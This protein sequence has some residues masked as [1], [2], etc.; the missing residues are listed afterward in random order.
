MQTIGEGGSNFGPAELSLAVWTVVKNGTDAGVVVV[1]AAG[2]GNQDLDS[3]TYQAYMARGNS[4]AIIVG[5]GT[6]TTAHDKL[7]FSTFGSR[8]NV[9][10]WGQSVFTAGNGSHSTIGG[11]PNQVYTATFSGTGSASP[12]IAA[13]CVALQSF[14]IDRI[15]RRLTPAELR[16]VLSTTGWPQG[17]GGNIGRF[18]NLVDAAL[19]VFQ[20]G[21]VLVPPQMLSVQVGS[22]VQGG[23]SSIQ[24]SD[25]IRLGA[26]SEI[27]FDASSLTTREVRMLITGT[28]PAG[29]VTRLG[30]RIEGYSSIPGISL[31]TELYNFLTGAWESVDF[32][33]APFPGDQFL[34]LNVPAPVERFVQP[35]TRQV[36]AK[37]T[38]ANGSDAVALGWSALMDHFTWVAQ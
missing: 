27:P 20:L 34:L 18:P 4:G 2:N 21:G 15:G 25:D 24:A 19:A 3:A 28:A 31:R 29:A 9:Q 35:G 11:D 26:T 8:V 38:F 32:R 16:S 13:S 30:I 22:G 5:A 14:A 1:G 37:V 10:G 6:A 12:F 33:T 17:T 23:L 36:R 7:S